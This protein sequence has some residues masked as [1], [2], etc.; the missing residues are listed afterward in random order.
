M[1]D[2][3]DGLINRAGRNTLAITALPKDM[4]GRPVTLS[5]LTLRARWSSGLPLY[6]EWGSRRITAILTAGHVVDSFTNVE[7]THLVVIGRTV[8]GGER[9]PI[10]V[11]VAD[12]LA[13]KGRELRLPEHRK[14]VHNDIGL[15][16]IGERGMEALLN[17]LGVIGYNPGKVRR[18]TKGPNVHKAFMVS[19][20]VEEL[21]LGEEEKLPVEV[22]R[23]IDLVQEGKAWGKEAGTGHRKCVKVTIARVEK[24]EGNVQGMSGSGVWE[25]CHPDDGACRLLGVVG[26]YLRDW[27]PEG[28]GDHVLFVGLEECLNQLIGQ[29]K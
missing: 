24:Q 25:E 29:R 20:N 14:T 11:S 3:Y 5:E 6:G 1:S 19:G 22:A 16:W 2:G 28:G 17:D 23:A 26:S 9:K 7:G 21:R 10:C 4:E 8:E 18:A 15:L 13:V 27:P 12:A